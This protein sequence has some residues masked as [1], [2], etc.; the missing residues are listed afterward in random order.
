MT[1]QIMKIIEVIVDFMWKGDRHLH[2]LQCG[3]VYSTPDWNLN[4][5]GAD[6]QV[7]KVC[8]IPFNVVWKASMSAKRSKF[9]GK[10]R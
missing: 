7:Q 2:Y 3:S 8:K 4:P 10:W 5:E 6:G 9:V 1:K